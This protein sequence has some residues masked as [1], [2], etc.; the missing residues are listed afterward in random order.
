MSGYR[1]TVIEQS[2][3]ILNHEGPDHKRGIRRRNVLRTAA[4]AC[5]CLRATVITGIDSME[6]LQQD[7]EA[8]RTF[9]P[10]TK[11]QVADLL[12]RT[13]QAASRGKFERFKTTNAFDGT[14]KNP[15]WLGDTDEGP[16]S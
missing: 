15:A 13:A 4:A 1:G 11:K 8:V 5:L 2:K 9:R 14:A 16:A 3:R 7:L 6:I 10:L 12:A